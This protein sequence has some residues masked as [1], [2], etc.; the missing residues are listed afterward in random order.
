MR[1]CKRQV[2]TNVFT[3]GAH[4]LG[5]SVSPGQTLGRLLVFTLTLAV[6][7]IDRPVYR[8]PADGTFLWHGQGVVALGAGAHVA[9]LQ[10]DAGALAAQA[11]GAAAGRHAALLQVQLAHAPPLLLLELLQHAPLPLD[12]PAVRVALPQ[13]EAERGAGGDAE[14]RRQDAPHPHA[15]AL[16]PQQ[17]LVVQPRQEVTEALLGR[18]QLDQVVVQD[19]LADARHAVAQ[20]QHL[21]RLVDALGPLAADEVADDAGQRLVGGVEVGVGRL[22]VELGGV[23]RTHDA[24]RGGDVVVEGAEGERH[25]VGA[26][27]D[28][29]LCVA[30]G[31]SK[32]T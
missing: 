22:Q 6:V 32:D 25:R 24:H 9:A 10:E 20:P 16:L 11:H 21:L 29:F 23:Q 17:S 13:D 4:L 8:R 19:Q 12:L 18:L 26:L 1:Q 5:F 30:P 27:V 14:D 2:Q 7:Q 15:A 28:D 3:V 31:S